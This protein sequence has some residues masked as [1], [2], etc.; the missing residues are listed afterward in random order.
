MIVKILFILSS[1]LGAVSFN[2]FIISIIHKDH[3]LSAILYIS[4]FLL[5]YVL[6]IVSTRNPLLSLEGISGC[7][8]A[9]DLTEMISNII[10]KK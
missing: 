2:H 5:L 3:R 1:V 7:I 8:I 6:S 9:M 10:C 4:A